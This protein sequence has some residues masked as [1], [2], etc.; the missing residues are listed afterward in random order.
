MLDVHVAVL[1]LRNS[2]WSVYYSRNCLGLSRLLSIF[3]LSLSLS[4]SLSFPLPPSVCV[5]N[6]P[7]CVCEFSSAL[8]WLC[9]LCVSQL[10]AAAPQ[11][12]GSN[13]SQFSDLQSL[14]CAALQ[15]LL[16]RVTKEDAATV[17]QRVFEALLAMLQTSSSGAVQE[18]VLMA[19]GSLVELLGEGFLSFMVHLKPFLLLALNA[20]DEHDVSASAICRCLQCVVYA[21]YN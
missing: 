8:V 17:G 21:C 12:N 19:V 2:N 13:R 20:R 14:L 10:I 9:R 4:L 1:L 15:A 18:D 6:I 5:F 3:F 16:R 11:V 7:G